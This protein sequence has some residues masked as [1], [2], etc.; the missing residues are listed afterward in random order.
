MIATISGE[1]LEIENDSLVV[2]LGGLGLRVFVPAAVR[3]R[4]HRG[5]MANLHTHL[6]VR[7]ELLALYGFDTVEAREFFTL[8]LG[9]NGVGPRIALMILSVL[10]T[11]AIRRAVVS[12]Q[13]EVFS[14]V[15]GVGKKTAQKILLHLQG[16]IGAEVGGFEGITTLSDIEA[17]IIGALTALGYS[18]V[19]AQAAV[20]AI[21]RDAPADVEM[22]LRLALQYFST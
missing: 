22:R 16:K 20:Q 5:E 7:E 19:E 17:E 9:V 8:L 12:E 4:A 10:S 14:R 2:G 6:V 21:P 15:P 13:S 3:D 1:V 18:I 11:D